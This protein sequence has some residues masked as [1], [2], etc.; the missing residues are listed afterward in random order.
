MAVSSGRMDEDKEY[1]MWR[2]WV[3][4]ALLFVLGLVT[5]GCNRESPQP[6]A[7][8]PAPAPAV[9]QE[10][11]HGHK[12]GSHGGNI[13]AI[14]RDNYHAEAIFEKEGT[15]RLYLLGKDETREQE[16]EAQTLRGFARRAAGTSSLP[17]E[18]QPQPQP[19]D[20]PGKTSQ[21]VGQLPAELRGQKTELSFRITIAGERYR[22]TVETP[23]TG[24]AEPM[25][26]KVADDA[27]RK[28]YLTP[29]GL[30]TVADIKANGERTASV[31]FK[32][33]MP[34]HDAHPRSGERI[35][36]I[37]ETKAN[38]QFAWVIGGQ[39]YEFCC[40]PCVDEF[41]TQA[42]EHP[43]AVKPSAAYIQ[44]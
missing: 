27:E 37:S 1:R 15:L 12:A 9:T 42:K 13:V 33:L 28:L 6:V 21:F 34:T 40:P 5:A 22:F 8:T 16:V 10:G 26:D 18:L 2:K 3:S 11:E 38:P 39:K 35:C 20:A 4:L 23:Q 19:E 14:G 36:P 32:G 7:T 24:H 44:K 29:G 25:P 31:A 17:I 41:L 43:E 30:Y